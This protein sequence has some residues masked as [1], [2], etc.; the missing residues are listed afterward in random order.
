MVRIGKVAVGGAMLALTLAG[1]AVPASAASAQL[2]IDA[3]AAG[4]G[5]NPTQFGHM[6][7]DINHSVDGGLNA[8]LV[9]NGTMKEN[10]ANPPAF[11]S[12]VTGGGGTGSLATDTAKPLN[13]ANGSALKLSI[14][15][16]GSG[17]RVGAANAG[18]FGIGVRPST[19]YRVSFFA[20]ADS[21][22]TGPLTV[23]L[24]ST[25]GTAYASATV[26]SIGQ[27]WRQYTATLTTSAS[28]PVS[29]AN[30]LVIAANATGAGHSVWLDVVTCYPPT[31]AGP[32]AFRADLV[33]KLAATAP[34]FLRLPGGNFL[35][36]TTVAT[37]FDWKATLGPIQNRPGH[38][39]DSWAY[40]STDQTGIL[41]YLEL[42]EALHAQPLL[43]VYAGYSAGTNVVPQG[44]LAPYIQDAL[45]EIEY[46][47][48]ATDTTWGAR[49]AADGHP[50]PFDVAYVEI[51]NEDN[52][53][54]SGSY[55]AYRYPMFYDAIRAAY[56]KLKIVATTKVTSRPMDVIDDHFYNSA[57]SWFTGQAHRY[58]TTS[59]TGP[60]HLIGE[61]AVR[62]AP[63][64][65]PTGTLAAAVGEAGFMVGLVRNADV[66]IG[67]AYAP[68][69]ANVGGFQ[70]NTNLIGFDA[71]T[72]YGAP[73][74]YV[75]QMFGTLHGDHVVA[76]ALT[77]ADP[78]VSVVASRAG[79]GR[80]YLT[81]VNPT[82]AA[83][84]T[85]VAVRGA[86]VGATATATTLTGDPTAV[87]SIGK[88]NAVMPAT[89]VV[90][91]G[92]AFDYTFPANSVTVLQ[93]PTDAVR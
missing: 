76:S 62:N 53:D 63:K 26:A 3:G 48:G 7:E 84:S 65:N 18:Y 31:A 52:F 71:S 72:S 8:N 90:A 60:K 34:G 42:A 22:F 77:G 66:V 37:R 50:A 85:A 4:P 44:E 5:I 57:P 47:T 74:Y 13:A 36:G 19:A 70:W 32:G 25:G 14:A 73:S 40:W 59:R 49:R 21:G 51:G 78:T 10:A 12:V 87:N 79:A 91:V 41:E 43:A 38:Q 55:D 54:H 2:T 45:D 64:G 17:Q 83:V 27:S 24:E 33:Q 56:P 75:Q 39:N 1:T 86:T 58:D 29:T 89:S 81:V 46:A 68:A 11:W 69:L 82:A 92:G 23:S 35:E 28:A 9:R 20:H 6:I 88:P 61:Y 30:R 16:N 80:T 93:L 15:A 67:A